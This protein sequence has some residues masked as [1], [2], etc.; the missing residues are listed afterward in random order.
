MKRIQRSLW[1][2]D[3][4]AWHSLAANSGVVYRFEGNSADANREWQVR[5]GESREMSIERSTWNMDNLRLAALGVALLL[6]GT[7]L[8]LWR[9]F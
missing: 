9:L 3:A 8:L 2:S 4:A 5:A 7:A 1:D 6:V